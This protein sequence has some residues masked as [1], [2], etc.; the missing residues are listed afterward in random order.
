M[1]NEYR[2]KL[3]LL[4]RTHSIKVCNSPGRCEALIRDF[5]GL[6]CLEINLLITALKRGVPDEMVFLGHKSLQYILSNIP[7]KLIHYDGLSKKN[8][9]W[10]V[11][12]W[13]IAL[14]V[15][16]EKDIKAFNE[17]IEV[18]PKKYTPQGALTFSFHGIDFIQFPMGKYK[19][20]SIKSLSNRNSMPAVEFEEFFISKYPVNNDYLL[21]FKD[22]KVVVKR[23]GS[24]VSQ[25]SL[26]VAQSII[27]KIKLL[28]R[29]FRFISQFV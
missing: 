27:R 24:T 6:P 1:E 22:D 17:A 15:T 2:K 18:I 19:Y 29:K 20:G 8:A 28:Y 4:I 11:E 3:F 13:A 21:I 12:S 26:Y 5:C 14:G 7:M 10:A 16:T 9:R 23:R 25:S